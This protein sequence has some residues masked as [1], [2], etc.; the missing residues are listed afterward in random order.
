METLGI[1]PERYEEVCKM[2]QVAYLNIPII[3]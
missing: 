1:D 3:D 2:A